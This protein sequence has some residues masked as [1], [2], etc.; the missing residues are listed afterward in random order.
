MTTISSNEICSVE[1]IE[2][3]TIARE[4]TKNHT[5]AIT[6]NHGL[7]GTGMG[8]ERGADTREDMKTVTKIVL[9]IR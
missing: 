8:V 6:R 4:T 7:E 5:E 1:R 3:V 2:K 9:H